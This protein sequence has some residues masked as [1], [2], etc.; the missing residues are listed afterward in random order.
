MGRGGFD[1]KPRRDETRKEK[2]RENEYEIERVCKLI[3]KKNE[4]NF[5]GFLKSFFL[6]TD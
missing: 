5:W 3:W 1:Y 2:K 4:T 6:V